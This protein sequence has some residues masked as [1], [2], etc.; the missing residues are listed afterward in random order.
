MDGVP[1]TSESWG[2]SGPLSR[3]LSLSLRRRIS[4]TTDEDSAVEPGHEGGGGGGG[5]GAEQRGVE[6]RGGGDIRAV[7]GVLWVSDRPIN[8]L[9]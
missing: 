2:L 1:L 5:G 9:K 8:T 6:V 3:F 4:S 7:P